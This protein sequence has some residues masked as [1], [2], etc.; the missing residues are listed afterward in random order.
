MALNF[1][2]HVTLLAHCETSF[3]FNNRQVAFHFQILLIMACFLVG[4]YLHYD[5]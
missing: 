3:F 1:D 4:C 5:F 2:Q